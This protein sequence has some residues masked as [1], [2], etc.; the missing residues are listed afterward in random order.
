[1]AGWQLGRLLRDRRQRGA[2]GDAHQHAFFGR[3]AA[4]HFAC[5]FGLDLDYTVGTEQPADADVR[6][7][8]GGGQVSAPFMGQVSPLRGRTG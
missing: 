2:A 7:V 4:R 8:A 1:L 3:R 5:G 6:R